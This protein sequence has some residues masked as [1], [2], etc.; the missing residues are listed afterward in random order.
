[1]GRVVLSQALEVVLESLLQ[2]N[3]RRVVQLRCGAL[4]I[5]NKVSAWG[6]L[7]PLLDTRAGSG[8]GYHLFGQ[9]AEGRADS[10]GDVVD[11]M[12]AVGRRVDSE[13]DAARHVAHVGE[14]PLAGRLDHQRLARQGG[15][16]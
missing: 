12:R 1:S 6:L 9:R 7:N 4:D 3:A 8:G 5:G 11:A 10:G 13:Q 15:P 14:V 16:G 2:R